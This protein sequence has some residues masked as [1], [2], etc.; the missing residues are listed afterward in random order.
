MRWLVA[1][2]VGFAGNVVAAVAGA[3]AS[4]TLA[5]VHAYLQRLGGHLD[6]ARRALEGIASGEIPGGAIDAGARAQLVA[7]FEPRVI[8]LQAARDAIA[9]ASAFA[10]PYALLVHYDPR[11]ASA[12]L[13]S[14]TPA[15]PVDMASL[16]FALAA[17]ALVWG[18]WEIGRA[19]VGRR[20]RSAAAGSPRPTRPS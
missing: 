12:T 6:E 5:F 1:K 2:I 15:V 3:A 17:V 10:K 14:F 7:S 9:Q 20:R 16:I 11:I 8:E 13:D 18:L 4:Q 19:V